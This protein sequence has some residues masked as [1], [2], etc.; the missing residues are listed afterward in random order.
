MLGAGTLQVQT[1]PTQ[2]QAGRSLFLA[3]EFNYV[4][5]PM[6]SDSWCSPINKALELV[7]TLIV[8]MGLQRNSL[9]WSEV[10][11]FGACWRWL[12]GSPWCWWTAHSPPD[13]LSSGHHWPESRPGSWAGP[14]HQGGGVQLINK[15]SLGAT[16]Q[17][18]VLYEPRMW[19][20]HLIF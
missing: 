5:R 3:E 18:L 15:A 10:E 11:M 20:E 19:K 16:N 1:S 12:L 7:H 14:T 9:W 17:L 6:F 8:A 13:P 4:Q 2:C